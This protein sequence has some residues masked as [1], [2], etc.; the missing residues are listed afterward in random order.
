MQSTKIHKNCL[1]RQFSLAKE[2]FARDRSNKF[3][4]ESTILVILTLSSYELSNLIYASRAAGEMERRRRFHPLS[5]SGVSHSLQ[6]P[7]LN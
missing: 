6:K 5:S 7:R 4:Q 2:K 1:R 3:L